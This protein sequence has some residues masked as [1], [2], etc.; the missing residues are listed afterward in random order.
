MVTRAIAAPAAVLLAATVAI[1]L[2]RMQLR[3]HDHVTKARHAATPKVAP[4]AKRTPYYV[5]HAG[6][7]LSAIAT[8]THLSLT[9][10]QKLNP[11]VQP[12]ALFLGEK[13]RL[14]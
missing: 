11:T 4:K 1:G 9:A 13:I 6:D 3:H 8:K 10:L 14:K 7:T 12:T 2:V 5:V